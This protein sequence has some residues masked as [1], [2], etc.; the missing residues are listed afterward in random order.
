MD[1]NK[2][3][4]GKYKDDI[5]SFLGEQVS[6]YK[7]NILVREVGKGGCRKTITEYRS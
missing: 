5:E 6:F 2:G 4:D 3:S 7:K 1:L